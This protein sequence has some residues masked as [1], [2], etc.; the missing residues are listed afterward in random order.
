MG[1]GEKKKSRCSF[2]LT[3]EHSYKKCEYKCQCIKC[4]W[5]NQLIN[6][7]TWV[8]VKCSVCGLE[9]HAPCLHKVNNLEFRFKL[10]TEYGYEHFPWDQVKIKDKGCGRGNQARKR[11]SVRD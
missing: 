1:V 4:S 9:G 11:R 7:C 10:Q 8:E 6:E 5:N 3:N 2:C